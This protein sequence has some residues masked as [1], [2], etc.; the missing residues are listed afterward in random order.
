MLAAA[1]FTAPTALPADSPA[2]SPEKLEALHSKIDALNQRIGEEISHKRSLSAELGKLEQRIGALYRKLDSLQSRKE[3]LQS[4]REKLARATQAGR[5]EASKA[6]DAL[7]K[8]LRSS[9]I[10]GRQPRI[11]LALQDEDPAQVA[12]MLAY[13]GYYARAH[14]RHITE[15]TATIAHYQALEKQLAATQNK[16]SRTVAAQQE[17]LS[18]LEKTRQERKAVLA[19]LNEDIAN[20]Q[21]R[22][23]QLK[24]DAAR[25]EKVIH[26]VHRDLDDLGFD[27][28]PQVAFSSLRGKLPWPVSG[29]IV[30]SF[31]SSRADHGALDWEAVRIAAPAGARVRAISYGRIA[32]TGWLPF[33]GLVLMVDHGDGYLV[34]YGHNEAIYR[35]VGEWVHPGEVIA[36]VGRSGGQ[37][38]AL[39]YFQIRHN[40][41]P[42]DPASWCRGNP[43][44]NR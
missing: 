44:R 21:T 3:Q 31:G 42:L 8:A 19:K 10:L 38:R 24:Q 40:D 39:L 16:L 6:Q 37:S 5:D 7:S 4:R 13:Y 27:E 11:K 30:A 14:A 33:Y 32:Y 12:R 25:L 35:Q 17:S 26:S 15:L 29:K 36:T 20:N 43:S 2:P 22:V 18:A 41:R 1:I 34:V 23:A 28:V 9:F